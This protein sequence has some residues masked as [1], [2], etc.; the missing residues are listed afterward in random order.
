MPRSPTDQHGGPEPA[1]APAAHPAC[2]PS[3]MSLLR[4]LR[5][6]HR[7]D[8]GSLRLQAKKRR[9]TG[10][11]TRTPFCL[12]SRMIK[13]QRRFAD[14]LSSKLSFCKH[15]VALLCA[16]LITSTLWVS[17]LKEGQPSVDSDERRGPATL[18]RCPQSGPCPAGPTC[19]AAPGRRAS[20]PAPAGAVAASV[21][22]EG[23]LRAGSAT[24]PCVC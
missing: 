13:L 10:Q 15:W 3:P 5:S 18:T 21:D 17:S 11:T 20:P 2:L 9:F 19:P 16:K 23:Q 14:S 7:G 6:P 4:R 12:H 22:R 1:L 24:A 8:P